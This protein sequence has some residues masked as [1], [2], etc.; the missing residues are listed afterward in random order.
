MH[1]HYW[2]IGAEF[3]T[4]ACDAQVPGTG[5]LIGPFPSYDDAHQVWRERSM[6]SRAQAT[7]RYTIVAAAPNP[8]RT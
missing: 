2:V 3:E 4:V 5:Q 6:D 8:R 7:T 1:Q